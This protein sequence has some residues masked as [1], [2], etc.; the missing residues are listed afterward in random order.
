VRTEAEQHSLDQLT[1]QDCREAKRVLRR[2][3]EV[4]PPKAAARASEV[5]DDLES[6]DLALQRRWN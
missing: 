1:I 5:I 3:V 2:L 4:L 6:E